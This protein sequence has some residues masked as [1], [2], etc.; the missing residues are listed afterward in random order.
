MGGAPALY[1]ERWRELEDVP[2]IFHSD[3]LLVEKPYRTQDLMGLP[4][5]HAVSI[6]EKR[7]YEGVPGAA[8]FW[9]NLELL[10][11][12]GVNFYI[13]FTGEPELRGAILDRFGSEIL[14]ESF[15]IPIRQYEATR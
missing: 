3:F 11:I 6:K 9:R 2:V 13:T 5:L 1:L 15:V 4:G 8:W 10:V 12:C 14:R 7:I